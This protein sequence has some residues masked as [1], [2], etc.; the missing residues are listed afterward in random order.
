MNR[1]LSATQPLSLRDAFSVVCGSLAVALAAQVSFPLPWTP[2]PVTLQPLAVMLVGAFLGPSRGA[3]AMF[4]Y[5]LEGA[6]GLP[7]FTPL[8]A[9]GMARILGPTGGYLLSYPLAAYTI[10]LLAHKG[11]TGTFK[12]AMPAFFATSLIILTFGASWM[13]LAGGRSLSE[14]LYLAVLPFLPWDIA[15]VFAAATLTS[16][17]RKFRQ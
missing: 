7:V 3:A 6:A 9:P 14:A 2:V 16:S 17:L 13:I 8:G 4:L 12:R 1:V 10:G 11:W 15:K 5:L